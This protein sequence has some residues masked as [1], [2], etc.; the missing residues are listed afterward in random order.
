MTSEEP[1]RG[2]RD[3]V[4]AE[5]QREQQSLGLSDWCLGSKGLLQHRRA[6][7]EGDG[8]VALAGGRLGILETRGQQR[9]Q[10]R[11]AC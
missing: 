9:L 7:K 5:G 8:I 4:I 6:G 11:G 1:L 3:E 10:S 2:V